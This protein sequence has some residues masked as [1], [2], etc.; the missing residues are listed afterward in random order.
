MSMTKSLHTV[1]SVTKVAAFLARIGSGSKVS[2][3]AYTQHALEILGYEFTAAQ[4]TDGSDDTLTRCIASV[5]KVLK[6]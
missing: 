1:T 6:G 5:A 3:V 2:A 4:L